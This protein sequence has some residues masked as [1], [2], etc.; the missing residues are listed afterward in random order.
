MS[1]GATRE[2]DMKTNDNLPV[3]ARDHVI[4]LGVAS[5]E[6]KGALRENEFVG[7]T[8]MAGISDE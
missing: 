8:I 1:R 7:G 4:E 3:D 6:T 2:T 5:I